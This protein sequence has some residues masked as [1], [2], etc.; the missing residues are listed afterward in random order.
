[1]SVG[2]RA[3]S[4]ERRS[5]GNWGD[6]TVEKTEI[7]TAA[8]WAC[9]WVA[10]R[11]GSTAAQMVEWMATHLADSRVSRSAENSV[12]WRASLT[13]ARTVWSSVG[14]WAP[15]WAGWMEAH[16]A[17]RMDSQKVDWKV[18]RWVDH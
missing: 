14:S 18:L 17:A 4:K 9:H 10:K 13:A 15:C 6:W 5:V 16:S 1:M 12:A 2:S 3:A 8:L 7:Q 11:A